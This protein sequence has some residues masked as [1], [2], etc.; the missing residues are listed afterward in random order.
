[1]PALHDVAIDVNER[2]FDVIEEFGIL[3]DPM[4]AVTGFS[5]ITQGRSD[6]P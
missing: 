5:I 3:N 6:A 2:A 1:L 4:S